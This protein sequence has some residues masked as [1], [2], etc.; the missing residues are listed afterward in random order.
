MSIPNEIIAYISADFDHDKD[1]VEKLNEWN[2]DKSLALSFFN[3]H[4]L[5]SSRDTS[6]YC[7]IK[8]SL[9]YRLSISNTFVLIVG[10]QTNTVSKGGCEYCRSYNS[11]SCACA[12]GYKIDYRSYIRFECEEAIKAGLKIVVLYKDTIVDQ[13]KCPEC[14][15]DI[16]F[17]VPMVHEQGGECYWSY[18]NVCYAINL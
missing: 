2:N 4:Y 9:R 5:Q 13:F 16:G 14:V 12:K 3:A 15:R 7:S 18:A 6:L 10:E 8:S 1:A 11:H 17:H